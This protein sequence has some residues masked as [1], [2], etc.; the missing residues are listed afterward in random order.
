MVTGSHDK[1]IRIW[2]KTE[3]PLF[4]EEERE[5][6]LEAMYDATA[7]EDASKPDELA[8]G[9]IEVEAV[10]KQTTE[11]LMAGEKIMEAL[12]LADAERE[13]QRQYEE[14]KSKLSAAAAPDLP[15]PSRSAELVARG[16]VSG[17]EHVYKT[18]KGVPA[19]AMEDALLVLPFRQ[20]V[21]LLTYLD[22]WARQVSLPVSDRGSDAY[23]LHSI[24]T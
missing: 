5:R 10:Q 15:A 19:A 2:E 18:L 7:V 13:A 3:E 4:L 12:D 20:V 1:S 17:E 16:D 9:D 21:S 11:T 24:A 6:E 22:E 8:D 14:E 23:G